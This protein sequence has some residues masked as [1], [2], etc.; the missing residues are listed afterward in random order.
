[1]LHQAAPLPAREVNYT[2]GALRYLNNG[3]ATN[4][5]ATNHNNV[6]GGTQS[7]GLETDCVY[8]GT[9]TGALGTPCHLTTG[10]SAIAAYDITGR[11]NGTGRSPASGPRHLRCYGA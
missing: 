1:M 7:Y 3:S 2:E 6:Q 9:T 4:H 8:G 10:W 11:R 5:N